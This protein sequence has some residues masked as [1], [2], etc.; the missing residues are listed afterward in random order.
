MHWAG[1]QLPIDKNACGTFTSLSVGENH[2]IL[3]NGL[4]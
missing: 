1:S 3:T 4:H 2:I